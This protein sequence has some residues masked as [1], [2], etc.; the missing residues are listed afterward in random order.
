LRQRQ[1]QHVGDRSFL[2]DKR[3]IHV[4]FPEPEVGVKENAQLR[5]N[6]SEP[7]GKRLATSITHRKYVASGCCDAQTAGMNE[8][9]E[10]AFEHPGHKSIAGP[11]YRPLP[12]TLAVDFDMLHGTKIILSK[13]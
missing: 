4:G 7:D 11:R 12:T 6:A 2:N 1:C 3:A 8:R 5:L 13:T 9:A 10:S